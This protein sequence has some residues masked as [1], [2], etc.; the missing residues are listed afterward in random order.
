LAAGSIA[1]ARFLN[2]SQ[3]LDFICDAHHGKSG[4][5][6]P[7]RMHGKTT[8]NWYHNTGNTFLFAGH[9]PS[10]TKAWFTKHHLRETTFAGWRR[11]RQIAGGFANRLISLPNKGKTYLKEQDSAAKRYQT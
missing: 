10:L 2:L 9:T 11:I 1:R 6:Q 7:S 8:P 4:I 3:E 5:A